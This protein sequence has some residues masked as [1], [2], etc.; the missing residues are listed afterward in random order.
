M[1]RTAQPIREVAC[2][3]SR[4]TGCNPSV[5]FPT[6]ANATALLRIRWA[7][8]KRVKAYETSRKVSVKRS[9]RSLTQSA[10]KDCCRNRCRTATPREKGQLID[11]I[12]AT[13]RCVNDED[14]LTHQRGRCLHT[15]SASRVGRQDHRRPLIQGLPKLVGQ[16]ARPLP[17][18]DQE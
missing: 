1:W 5:S 12:A 14:V 15:E 17:I 16:E 11:R 7:Y 18:G 9:L 10:K 8:G 3:S 4:K 6:P 13:S 2:P